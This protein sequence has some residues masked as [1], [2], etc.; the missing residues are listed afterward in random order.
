M[1]NYMFILVT[2]FFKVLLRF[3]RLLLFE[4]IAPIEKIIKASNSDDANLSKSVNGNQRGSL[5]YKTTSLKDSFFK[6]MQ[7]SRWLV[8]TGTTFLNTPVSNAGR[9]K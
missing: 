2:W 4:Y 3:Q 6:D 8:V 9:Q 1:N 5:T 7:L